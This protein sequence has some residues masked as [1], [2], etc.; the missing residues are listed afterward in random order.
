MVHYRFAWPLVNPLQEE[1][2]SEVASTDRRV[3]RPAI[4]IVEQS[5]EIIIAAKMSGVNKADVAVTFEDGLLTIRGERK[6][7]DSPGSAQLLV[8]EIS[9]RP[10]ERTIRFTVPVESAA[11]TAE[12]EQGVL[13][14]RVPKAEQAR[15]RTITIK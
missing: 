3:Q 5:N 8:N 9:G 6:P 11:I 15:Q 13:S 14:V 10:I 4:N 7:V 1:S 2:L 12:L